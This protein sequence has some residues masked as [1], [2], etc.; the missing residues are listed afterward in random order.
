MS[1]PAGFGSSRFGRLHPLRRLLFRRVKFLRLV[2]SCLTAVR[3]VTIGRSSF[4]LHRTVQAFDHSSKL[5]FR[6]AGID[7]L[8]LHRIA[9]H[10]RTVTQERFHDRNPVVTAVGPASSAGPI[11]AREISLC[12]ERRSEDQ[13]PLPRRVRSPSLQTRCRVQSSGSCSEEPARS[14]AGR[15][16][17]S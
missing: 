10:R 11:A 16:P 15:L 13:P 8:N 2:T 7:G 5:H 12:C 3:L 1:S 14:S 4:H 6:L 17:C 9:A